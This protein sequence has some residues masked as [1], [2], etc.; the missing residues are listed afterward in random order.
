MSS[1]AAVVDEKEKDEEVKRYY[2]IVACSQHVTNR[3]R[4]LAGKALR[5]YK[6]WNGKKDITLIYWRNGRD[7]AKMIASM[8]KG[9]KNENNDENKYKKIFI[10]IFDKSKYSG[11]SKYM[12]SEAEM[13][14]MVIS[15]N[16]AVCVITNRPLF[17]VDSNGYS[18]E[19]LKADHTIKIPSR[20]LR[21]TLY[22]KLREGIKRKY[23]C[24]CE[25]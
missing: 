18:F 20:K 13:K 5:K 22:C 2:L 17:Y 25:Y 16:T 12:G 15:S 3:Q 8:E 7:V 9:K 21:K 10:T 1:S 14:N 6:R 19:S 23:P 11:Y 4:K 24:T